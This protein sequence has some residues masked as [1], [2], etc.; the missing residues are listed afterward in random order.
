MDIMKNYKFMT[1]NV[2]QGHDRLNS[3]I[4]PFSKKYV[5]WILNMVRVRVVSKWSLLKRVFMI[6]RKNA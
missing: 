5:P 1:Q 6:C 2:L 4:D 3:S